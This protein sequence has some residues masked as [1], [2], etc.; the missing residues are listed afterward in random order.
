MKEDEKGVRESQHAVERLV[1]REIE[2]GVAAGRIV[3]AGFSQ[4]GAI[5]LQTGLRYPA[6]L[7]GVLSLSAYLPLP[8]RLEAERHASNRD[9]PIFMAHGTEDP[10]VPL[11]LAA[12]SCTRLITMGYAVQWHEYQMPHSVCHEEIR[13]IGAWLRQALSD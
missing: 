6:R 12:A 11:K 1:A 9:V 10:I 5:A 7:A 4:G 3:L 8:D 2:R 13:D